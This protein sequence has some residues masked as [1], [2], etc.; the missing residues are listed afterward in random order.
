MLTV[1]GGNENGS[2]GGSISIAESSEGPGK[3]PH[4]YSDVGVTEGIGCGEAVG[5]LVGIGEGVGVSEGAGVYVC[6][7]GAMGDGLGEDSFKS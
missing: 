5:V 3:Y 6:V 1:S 4:T 2:I 7:E